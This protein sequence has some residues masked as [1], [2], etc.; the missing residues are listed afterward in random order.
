PVL[1]KG[2]PV[3]VMVSE[4]LPLVGEV[5]STLTEEHRRRY[6]AALRSFRAGDWPE[7]LNQARGMPSDGPTEFVTRY[8]LANRAADGKAPADWGGGI[9]VDQDAAPASPAPSTRGTMIINYPGA[10]RPG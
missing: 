9:P 8:I 3:P 1:P 4:L 2:I 5:G 10:E 6:E 7:F